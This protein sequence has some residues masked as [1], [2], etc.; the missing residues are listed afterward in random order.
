MHGI[1]QLDLGHELQ[2]AAV[3]AQHQHAAAPGGR[4]G[5]ARQRARS[6]HA[7]RQRARAHNQQLAALQPQGRALARLGWVHSAASPKALQWLAGTHAQPQQLAAF[8]R[9]W[10]GAPCCLHATGA[11]DV[12]Q[13][14]AMIGEAGCSS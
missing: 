4:G 13:G 9:P 5:G 1:R 8:C 7:R 6:V 12:L 10:A 3:R 11:T 14:G 2:A